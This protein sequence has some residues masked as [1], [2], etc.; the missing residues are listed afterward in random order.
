MLTKHPL[1]FDCPC[2]GGDELPGFLLQPFEFGARRIMRFRMC[3]A[4]LIAHPARSTAGVLA[5]E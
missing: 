1:P 5:Q 4:R 2:F 3:R